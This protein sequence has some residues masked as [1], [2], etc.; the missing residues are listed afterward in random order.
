MDDPNEV[1]V[2]TVVNETGTVFEVTIAPAD[3]GKVIGKNGGSL[4]L[5]AGRSLLQAQLARQ[6][7]LRKSNLLCLNL[8]ASGA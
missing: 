4:D 7:T 6:N 1:D 8:R 3:V 5:E 2:T